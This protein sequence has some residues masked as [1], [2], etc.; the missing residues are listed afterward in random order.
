MKRAAVLAMALSLGTPAASPAQ[1]A[2]P[3]A[4]VNGLIASWNSHDVRLLE[5][6]LARDATWVTV[7]GSRLVGLAAVQAYIGEEHS[8]WASP[9]SMTPH[10]VAVRLLAPEHAVISFEGEISGALREGK[11]VAPYRVGNLLVASKGST[12]WQVVAG[13]LTFVRPPSQH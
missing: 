12:G 6:V 9:T 10:N 3:E 8:T 5:A 4:L 1:V 13:Q 7:R 2:T 11:P